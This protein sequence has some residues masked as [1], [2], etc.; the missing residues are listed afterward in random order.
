[1]KKT[2]NINLA[3]I[4]FIIDEDAYLMMH[5]YLDAINKKLGSNEA[6]REI[7]QDIE[8]R[9]AE[10]FTADKIMTKGVIDIQQVN[11]A[12]KVMGKPEDIAGENEFASDKTETQATSPDM[13]QQH[14]RRKLYRNAD[15][16]KLG[17]VISGIAAYFGIESPTLLRLAALVLLF[18]SFGTTAFIYIIL[19]IAMPEAITTAQKL[20]MKG[21]PINIENIQKEVS[22][23][24][25]RL[26]EWS[27]HGNF[28]DKLFSFIGNIAK[29]IV[30]L[31]LIVIIFF[32]VVI[33]IGLI[34]ASMGV[35]SIASLAPMQQMADIFLESRVLLFVALVGAILLVLTPLL[36]LLYAGIKVVAGTRYNNSKA[37]WFLFSSFL[38]G[39]LLVAIAY[40]TFIINFKSENNMREQYALMQPANGSLSVQLADSSAVVF[41]NDDDDD[42]YF[43]NFYFNG[44]S[45]KTRTGYKAGKP[46]LKLMPSKD[47][48]FY[49]IK[50]VD[51]KGRTKANALANAQNINYNFTQTDTILS[52]NSY[53]EVKNGSKWRKQNV[54]IYLAIPE[55][56]TIYFSSNIDYIA[57]GIKDDDTYDNAHFAGTTWTAK[58]GKV[59]R[60]ETPEP[61][62]ITVQ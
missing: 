33:L 19:W 59:V 49:I 24:A 36:A 41:S 58:S 21:A 37:K 31:F 28:L 54:L 32:V 27:T 11:E 5:E 40:F 9:L 16:K 2:V 3:G 26:N 14:V 47:N 13:E 55:G 17:G 20:E 34:A 56:K 44:E 35:L 38:M 8:A 18:F 22:D 52:L 43:S 57:T 53:F 50:V 1:M 45:L 25:S 10:L 39:L 23:A 7:L 60:V 42:S 61:E 15:D 6:A 48:S 30:K 29:V 12:I 62:E 4:A 46:Q 51:S